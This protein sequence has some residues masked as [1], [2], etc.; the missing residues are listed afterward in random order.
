MLRP[1]PDAAPVTTVSLSVMARRNSLK[2]VFVSDYE[3]MIHNFAAMFAISDGA[4]QALIDMLGQLSK[5][6]TT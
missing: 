1:M 5:K 6:I 3:G 2:P 4:N